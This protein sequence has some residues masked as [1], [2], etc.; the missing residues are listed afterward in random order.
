M[1]CNNAIT[2]YNKGYMKITIQELDSPYIDEVIKLFKELVDYVQ[3]E[4][5]DPYFEYD[6][7]NVCFVRSMFN[8]FVD[9]SCA[10]V[11][12]AICDD[13]IIG[14]IAGQIQKNLLPFSNVSNVGYVTAVF[15]REDYRH[16]GV[17]KRLEEKMFYFF[18]DNDVEYIDLNV[19]SK[20]IDAIKNWQHLG[21]ETFRVQMRK[22]I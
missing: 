16:Q 20:N 22:K 13:K 5:N 8:S 15:V 2:Y 3:K 17:M 7:F 6:E 9:D 4:T 1:R 18:K 19:L 14:F 10:I 12:V 21:Y 11:Y